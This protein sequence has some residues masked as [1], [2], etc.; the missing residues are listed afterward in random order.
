MDALP[1]TTVIWVEGGP[2]SESA[3]S[4]LARWARARGLSLRSIESG[5][6]HR[7]PV[8]EL[9]LGARVEDQ[10]ARARIGLLR[11]DAD[12]V[13]T[14]LAQASTLVRA[15]PEWPHAA[16]LRAEV[17]RTW[18]ARYVRLQPANAARA[19]EL[20]AEA[21]GLDGGRVA[22]IGD[23]P[24]SSA[25]SIEASVA[26][27][28]NPRFALRVDGRPTKSGPIHV[29]EGE[30]HMYV[31]L[32][33]EFVWGGWVG[34]LNGSEVAVPA[35]LPSPCSPGDLAQP[36]SATC[37]SW[38]TA[39]ESKGDLLIT[40]CHLAICTA[41]TALPLSAATPAIA[42]DTRRWPLWATWALVGVGTIAVTTVAL[43]ASGS[44]DAP[45]RETRFANGGVRPA[46]TPI[47]WS[48]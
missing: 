7:A 10:I 13:D 29:T 11:G 43:V 39:A 37:P 27:T 21:T 14:E 25:P 48:H 31:T 46:D 5:R 26:F 32:D 2:P 41:P 6:A 15:H 28:G 40:E 33:G 3:K 9:S 19:A 23:A 17:D 47:D 42:A 35:P 34:I 44:F 20:I 36:A 8:V 45:S 24:A 30:H 12:S 22:A 1:E 38:L 4:A 16:W 18:A